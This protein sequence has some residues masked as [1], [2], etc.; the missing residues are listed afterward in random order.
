MDALQFFLLRHEAL[1]STTAQQSVDTLLSQLS[2][3]QL[4]YRPRPDLNSIAWIVWHM[5]RCEDFGVQRLVGDRPQIF[6]QQ[7]W[8]ARLNIPRRDC[9]TGMADDEVTDLSAR[10][11][12]TALRAYWTTVGEGTLAVV[13][14]LHPEELDEALDPAYLHQVIV[15]EGVFRPRSADLTRP[16]ANYHGRNRGWFLG[17]LGLT[18]NYEHV[19]KALVIRGLQG[20][21]RF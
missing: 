18:H 8:M 5:A 21:R 15:E 7:G 17:H 2:E 10:V 13:H 16:G 1:R 12:L 11:D 14:T 19:A 9:G 3:T 20:L 6:D 4:R